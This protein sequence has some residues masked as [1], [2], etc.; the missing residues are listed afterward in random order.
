VKGFNRK[1]GSG[2]SELDRTELAAAL[3]KLT[4]VTE[5]ED[6][7]TTS[8][9][10][11]Q[12]AV[13]ALAQPAPSAQENPV[14]GPETREARRNFP[15]AGSN[16]PPPP[17]ATTVPLSPSVPEKPAAAQAFGS[18]QEKALLGYE[19]L[20]DTVNMGPRIVVR[21]LEDGRVF[22]SN[23]TGWNWRWFSMPDG[24]LV[25]DCFW[26]QDEHLYLRFDR[27]FTEFKAYGDQGVCKV[28]G[29]RLGPIGP[30][31]GTH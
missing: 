19:W 10:T 21:F 5:Q 7:P 22:R 30:A 27:Q 6:P 11:P 9:N 13:A 8:A 17:A 4:P 3:A 20:W 28:R 14:A 18:S 29:K 2:N 25:V 26:R 1:N 31:D 12:P 23:G 15:I 16:P 24:E